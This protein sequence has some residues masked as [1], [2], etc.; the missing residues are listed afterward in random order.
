MHNRRWF[1]ACWLLI[2]LAVS[3]AWCLSSARQLSATFDEP[4]YLE[5]GLERWRSGSHAGLM[6]L[7]TMPLPIDWD[8]LPLYA[9]E[10]WTGVPFDTVREL[11]RPLAWARTA[12]LAFW[13][14]L[15]VYGWLTARA[16]AGPWAGC[17]AIA[18][19]AC[20]PNLLSHA[21]LATTDVPVSA[22]LLALA[23]HF[24]AGRE[25][26][27]WRRVGWPGL[28]F[29]AAVLAKASGMVF[30][31]LCLI[32]VE[33]HRMIQ[34][35]MSLEPDALRSVLPQAFRRLGVC[36]KRSPSRPEDCESTS[37]RDSRNATEGV[38]Y[39][40]C[41]DLV[42]IALVGFAVTFVYCG[43]D[44][45]TEPSFVAW[46]HS[47]PAGQSREIM[48]WLSEHLAI[49]SNAGEGLVRQVK[50]NMRGHHGS[51][52]FGHTYDKPLWYYFPAA[53]AVKLTLSVLLAPL[54]LLIARRR[55]ALNWALAAALVLFVFSLT[56]RVQIGIRLMLP[57]IVFL[58]TG[59]AAAFGELAQ[60]GRATRPA[61]I[62]FAAAS[63]LWT[64]AAAWRV[65]P[66][67]LCYT[68]VLGGGTANGYLCLSDS[69]YDWGQGLKELAEW[70][71][72]AGVERLDVWYF[73]TD[74]AV[75][76][77]PLRHTP[78]HILP[79]TAPDELPLCLPGKYLAVSTTLAFGTRMDIPAQD[80]AVAYLRSRR[81]VA[82]TST[83]LIYDLSDKPVARSSS[84]PGN[85]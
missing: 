29:G 85:R 52:L 51:Y 33:A 11:D 81:P 38:P 12:A 64:A 2:C 18:W 5:R 54:V 24:R 25:A 41:R 76:Q 30:G 59:I 65:W 28:W 46:A 8:T 36:R 47:L 60:R 50:H 68:N 7:G 21:S 48:S 43:C 75:N 10:R 61:W 57:L 14:L 17:L 31:P 63:I 67:G 70:S 20:E 26:R 16:I 71:E 80:H 78:L 22:C 82:R 55:R 74:P 42:Q 56:C 34:A 37:P 32:A 23:Y 69:N 77:P 44:W 62:V 39:S 9:Y 13:W 45:R 79:I 19:L 66:E 49:F 83:F 15:L 40:V 35:K 58:V 27:W 4:L 6:K 53:L 3:S 1:D 73:G 72:Q 84:R